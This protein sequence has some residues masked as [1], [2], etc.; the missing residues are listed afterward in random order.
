SQT[1]AVA[2][3]AQA[4]PATSTQPNNP[5]LEQKEYLA[6]NKL[7]MKGDY[8]RAT[9]A[10]QNLLSRYPNGQY[11]GSSHY[12]LGE[13]YLKQGQPD[14]AIPEFNTVIMNYPKNAKVPDATL[15]LGFAYYDQGDMKKA[16]ALLI[17]V[18]KQ[19]KNTTVAQLAL[20]RLD[21]MKQQ[22]KAASTTSGGR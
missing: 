5:A 18:T 6:A 7:M 1:A 22:N 21:D 17:K 16:R 2:M 8:V 13:I 12:W 15:K 19:Y 9:T 20:A 14:L 4:L 11:A 10:L 3:P